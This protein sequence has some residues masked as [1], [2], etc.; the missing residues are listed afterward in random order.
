M[1]KDVA[2]KFRASIEGTNGIATEAG[3][4]ADGMEQASGYVQQHS[5]SSLAG[6]L[7]EYVRNHPIQAVLGLVVAAVAI[8]LVLR[9]Y[10]SR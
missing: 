2:S 6:G 9:S 10:A 1:A 5:P 3:S 7:V 4:V 8:R